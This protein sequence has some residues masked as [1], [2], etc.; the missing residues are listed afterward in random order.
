MPELGGRFEPR[1]PSHKMLMIVLG[2]MSESER[3]HVQARVR[4]AMDAQVINEGR[5]QGGRA[6][7]GYVVSTV[8]RTRIHA[9]PPRAI[10]SVSSRSTKAILDDP[11]Y[12]GHAVFGRHKNEVLLD[13]DDVSAGHV[14]RFRR[15]E[16][17]RVAG[18]RWLGRPRT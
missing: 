11:R 1:N 15:S 8:V 14:V 12:T 3:Q 18:A 17:S 2:G 13:P 7:Y 5:E 16:Q 10:A 9:R 6:P 4:A